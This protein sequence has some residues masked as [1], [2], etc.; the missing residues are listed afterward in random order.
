LKLGNDGK[1]IP[2]SDDGVNYKTHPESM[3]LKEFSGF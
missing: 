3:K 1:A 2:I